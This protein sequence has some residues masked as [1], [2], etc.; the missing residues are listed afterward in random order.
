MVIL[1]DISFSQVIAFAIAASVIAAGT[2]TL[3][4][5]MKGGFQMI[6]AGDGD[7][8]EEE[9]KKAWLTIRYAILGLFIVGFAVVAVHFAGN[10]MGADFLKYLDT[11]QIM[12]M[13]N[14]IIKRLSGDYSAEPSTLDNSGVLDF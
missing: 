5:I 8:A 11:E 9:K 2:M 13:F 10:F 3:F 1:T 12:K 6:M 14:L 4:F 7:D